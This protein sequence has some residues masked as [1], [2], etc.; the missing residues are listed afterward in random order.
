M[1]IKVAILGSTGSIGKT[2]IKI[3][4]KNKK[5]YDIC[6]LS[7]NKNTKEILKQANYF[8]VKNLIITDKENFNKFKNEQ[9]K[10]K[11]N[12][13]NNFDE[14]SKILKKKIDYTMSSISGL[15]GLEPTLKIIKHTKKIAI[16]NKESIICGWN[17]INKE[18]IKNSTV[19]IPVDSEHFSIWSLL[20][21]EKNDHIDEVIITA[22][23]GPFLNY[24][25]KKFNKITPSM[26]IKHPNWS[27]GKKISIDSAT[28]MNKVFEII[29]AQRIFDIKI[30]KFKIMT[31]P[32]SYIHAI[33]KFKNG[34]IKLLAHET[35]MS[36]PIY[37]SL[38]SNHEKSNLKTK[39]IDFSILNNLNFKKVD[40]KKFPS[41]KI[42][43]NIKDY[44]TLYETAIVSAND[45]LVDLFLKKKIKFTDLSKHLIK[46]LN[47]KQIILLKKKKPSN[48]EDI[49]L[50]NE[51]VKLKVMSVCI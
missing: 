4:K 17:L 43:K 48:Y 35:S 30:S 23:G 15:D 24:P 2:T 47:D 51:Y 46:I 18:I 34:L 7:T 26:A 37:N 8:N 16:A 13:Y 33:V 32:D 25:I 45:Q 9:N 39:R 5:N 1:K 27:M 42:L 29:E 49:R 31:H 22:S 20:N 41:I 38:V 3:L 14:L 12:I 10:K 6:L 36:I 11:L 50:I 21:K 40:T 19:F 44:S 28:L